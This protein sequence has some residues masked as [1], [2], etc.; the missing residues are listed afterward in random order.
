MKIIFF[1][2]YDIR[3][4]WNEFKKRN[5]IPWLSDS[6][7][8]EILRKSDLIITVSPMLKEKFKYFSPVLIPNGYE[9]TSFD[10]N[11]IISLKK[12]NITFGYYG[13]L[14]INWFDWDFLKKLANLKKDW[15]FHIIGSPKYEFIKN[16]PNN[17]IYHGAVEH[18]KLKDYAKNWDIAIIPFKDN[19]IS[20][21]SD[22]LK[23]YEFLYFD[24][25]V[26]TKGIPHL[27]KYP[28]TFEVNTCKEFVK[29][30]EKIIKNPKLITEFKAFINESTW[31]NR[32]NYLFEVI[33]NR[34]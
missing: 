6:A 15:V 31:E 21:Y 3:D 23:T 25:P 4:N 18:S 22:P 29:T 2:I 30:A 26:I 17:I 33:K 1:I 28:N 10:D 5:E 11:F 19:E 8:Q 9:P 34:K 12:G 13:T 24:L 16:M 20:K 7:E 14:N 27:S 32:V